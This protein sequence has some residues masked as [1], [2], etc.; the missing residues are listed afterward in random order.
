[1]GFLLYVSIAS[2]LTLVPNPNSASTSSTEAAWAIAIR[3][4]MASGGPTHFTGSSS[5]D[6]KKRFDERVTSDASAPTAAKK[7]ERGY[8]NNLPDLP[9]S[10]RA[11]GT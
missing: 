8:G 10:N 2:R 11:L 1:M 4:H 3:P 7:L 6:L 5:D 9:N